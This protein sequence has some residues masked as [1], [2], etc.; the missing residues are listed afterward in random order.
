MLL[1]RQA[2]GS[3]EM[4]PLTLLA[5]PLSLVLPL[6]LLLLR[7]SWNL[8]DSDSEETSEVIGELDDA[9]RSPVLLVRRSLHR[10]DHGLRIL[11]SKAR[12]KLQNDR[13]DMYV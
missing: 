12:L 5:E 11:H 6:P 9:C 4:F 1:R 7:L 3:S 2:D 8:T 10:V 13:W